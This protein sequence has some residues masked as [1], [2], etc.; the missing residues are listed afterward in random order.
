VVAGHSPDGVSVVLSDWWCNVRQSNT[1]PLLRLNAEGRDL[2][3]M[4]TVRDAVLT[5][6]RSAR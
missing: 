6:I 1:E 4:V 3:T 5:I 2:A